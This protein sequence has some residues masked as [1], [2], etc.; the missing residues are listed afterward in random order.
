MSLFFTLLPIYLFGN[1]HCLGMCGPLV[2]MIG[3]HRYRNFYFFGRTI[4]FALVGLAAGEAG[5]VLQIGL[6]HLQ[7]SAASSFLFGGIILTA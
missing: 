5:S 3:R 1:L 4:S 6:K 2:M 7:I